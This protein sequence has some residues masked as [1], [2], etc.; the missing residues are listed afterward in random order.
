[1]RE[2]APVLHESLPLCVE[3]L[4]RAKRRAVLVF[5]TD[6]TVQGGYEAWP[7]PRYYVHKHNAVI[8]GK[9]LDGARVWLEHDES[10]PV[11]R[12]LH[13][14]LESG[15]G[16]VYGLV[17][18]LNSADGMMAFSLLECG[19]LWGCSGGIKPN[20]AFRYRQGQPTP[21]GRCGPIVRI[22]SWTLVEVTL[23]CAPRQPRTGLVRTAG[24]QVNIEAERRTNALRSLAASGGIP[25]NH[26]EFLA[27]LGYSELDGARFM[28]EM[29]RDRIAKLDEAKP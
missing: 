17:E 19:R 7:E 21:D 24:H 4:D 14:W 22:E 1:M 20:K 6:E 11:A 8:L 29:Q 25:S 10:K 18:F 3:G 16:R 26:A 15:L 12:V 13:A 23:C 9:L 28:L 5:T 2:P 27:E